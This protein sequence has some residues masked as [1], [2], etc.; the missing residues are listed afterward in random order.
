MAFPDTGGTAMPD[1]F[2]GQKAA[3]LIPTA[4]D[5][6]A[7]TGDQHEQAKSATYHVG[8][9]TPSPLTCLIRYIRAAQ[10]GK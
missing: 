7:A 3:R 6:H 5:W 2:A 1:G 8:I 9:R 4:Q 10:N